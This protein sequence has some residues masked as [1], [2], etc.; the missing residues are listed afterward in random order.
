VQKVIK[1]PSQV[2]KFFGKNPL[3][4]PS[5]KTHA[6]RNSISIVTPVII[7]IK[8]FFIFTASNDQQVMN[9][10]IFR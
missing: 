10:Q 8:D 3:I 9:L 1:P 5:K 7:K 4:K 2:T 6:K